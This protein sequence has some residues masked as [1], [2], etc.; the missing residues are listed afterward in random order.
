MR[1]VKLVALVATC[2]GMVC[3]GASHA[4]AQGLPPF[5]FNTH[6]AAIVDSSAQV[7]REIMTIPGKGIPAS[8]LAKSEGIVIVP[9]MLKGGFVIGAKHGRG[10]VVVRDQNA[11]WQMPQFITI[12]GGSVGWQAG[13]QATDLVL[14]FMTKKSVQGLLTGKFTIGADASAAA[15]PVGREASASTDARLQAEIYSYS[16]SRGLFAGLS[17]D[18]SKISIDSNATAIYYRPQTELPAG[19]A[20]PVPASAM[21]LMQE[22]AKYSATT[23]DA[24]AAPMNVAA[25][26]AAAPNLQAAPNQQIAREQLAAASQRLGAMVDVPWRNYLALPAETYGGPNMP[27][28]EGLEQALVKFQTVAGNPQY[29]ALAS[30]P[31][32]KETLQ[33]LQQMIAATPRPAIALPPPPQ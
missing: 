16:R 19:Q 3:G 14:V 4:R 11:N 29:A 21:R 13:I 23:V 8:L 27:A 6:E 31:E 10:V 15:G 25:A 28:I 9:G 22:I 12:T 30:R 2:C 5:E 32:F 18:G 1:V 7:L 24:A 26:P 33:L 20:A 17:V